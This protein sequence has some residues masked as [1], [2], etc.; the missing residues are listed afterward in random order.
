MK[1]IIDKVLA[2]VLAQLIEEG[3]VKPA[4]L[5]ESDLYEAED[6]EEIGYSCPINPEKLVQIEKELN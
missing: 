3:Y 2:S 6:L 4:C 1:E 5:D